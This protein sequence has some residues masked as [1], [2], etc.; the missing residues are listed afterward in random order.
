MAPKKVVKKAAKKV[1]A[2]KAPAKKATKAAKKT[3]GALEARVTAL[4]EQMADL[5][6]AVNPSDV[7]SS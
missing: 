3:G 6:A 7:K 2:K 1:P 5:M 4:E